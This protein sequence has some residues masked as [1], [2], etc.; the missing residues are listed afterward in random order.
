MMKTRLINAAF[1]VA[2]IA[3]LAVM[4]VYVLP[5]LSRLKPSAR[6]NATPVI[7][8]QVQGLSNLVT[9]KYVMEKV[10]ILDDI[11]PFKDMIISGWG[12]NRVLMVAHGI[13]NAGINLG[14]LQE[15]DIQ[16]SETAGSKR[17]IVIKLPPARVTDKY[18]DDKLT[19]VVEYK[20]GMLRGFD[21]DLEQN[22]RQ[23]AVADIDRA[24]REAGILKDAEERARIQLT[25]LFHQLGF[26]EVEFRS[27]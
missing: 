27:P 17:K 22:A 6:I 20:T 8:Q 26:E 13:V 18:L 23:Q 9:V 1:I 24:A 11:Q 5:L 15:G 4:F 19:R 7:L 10:V 12:D 14:Q 16:I 2:I 3:G 21:K 25:N